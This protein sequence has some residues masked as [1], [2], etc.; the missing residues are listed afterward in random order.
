MR[1][2]FFTP[3]LGIGGAQTLTVSYVLGMQRRGHT[4]GVAFGITDVG[5]QP[6]R[7][8]GVDLFNLSDR[9]LRSKTLP[10]WVRRLRSTI[11]TFRPDVIHAQSVTAAL[12]A[13]LAA[14]RLPVLVT[15]HGISS[16]DEGLASLVFRLANVK[17]SAVSE[18]SAAGLSRH[19]W[20]PPVELLVPG[21]DSEWIRA[22]S[23][24]EEVELI[25]GPRLCCVARQH[26]AKGVDVLIRAF[27]IV[28]RELPSAG[29]TLVGAGDDLEQNRALAA[30]LGVGDRVRFTGGVTNAAP[31]FQA[32]DVVILP[33]R[34]EGL[35]VAILEA[36]VLE[37]PVVATRV[38]GTPTVVVDGETGWLSPP[39]DEDAL[40]AT[41]VASLAD[42]A[43]GARRG[44]AGRLVVEERFGSEPMLDRLERLLIAAVGR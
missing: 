21:I 14:P 15:V 29:L 23:T 25:G 13:R 27:A 18:A 10:E 4:A 35:P 31:Y 11:R 41:I 7:D 19:R 5:A 38:G 20:T 9:R 42:P 34:R 16:S 39:E 12:A 33:S 30:E 26:P 40:A 24:A 36:L 8:V 2:L 43:E 17:L 28:N 37:R 22:Q 44:R 6:L 3:D 32:A 1:I